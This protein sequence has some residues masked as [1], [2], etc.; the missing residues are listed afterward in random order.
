MLGNSEEIR[1]IM[2]ILKLEEANI[3]LNSIGME[4][5][6]WNRIK[7]IS[8]SQIYTL[9]YPAPK[10]A[11]E[12]V[13]FSQQI[14]GW[15]PKGDWKIL[16]IEDASY[17]DSAEA[18]LFDKLIDSYNEFN[19]DERNISTILYEFGNDINATHNTE[20]QIAYLIFA[21]L[22]FQQHCTFASSN[23]CFGERLGIQDGFVYFYTRNEK[24]LTETKSL[25]NDFERNPLTAPPWILEIIIQGQKSNS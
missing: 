23:S 10:I 12:L 21:F 17:F 5:D 6:E 24:L 9:N 3:C 19:L 7:D 18:F 1:N 4:I 8:G 22:L 16:Q 11:R 15:L 20:L 14:A 13:C 25:L 2:G